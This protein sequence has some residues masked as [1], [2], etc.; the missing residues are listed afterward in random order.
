MQLTLKTLDV[1]VVGIQTANVLVRAYINATPIGTTTPWTNVV[2]N[3]TGVVN[4][5]L[6]QIADYGGG[7]VTVSGGEVT[8]GFWVSGTGSIDI[9]N[10]RDLGNCILG[11]GGANSNTQIYP[12]G[13]DVLTIVATNYTPG[14][15]VTL[16]GR[17]GWTEAQA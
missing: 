10:V 2:N 8:G 16:Q 11:G 12:D 13:P 7:S 6:A 17:I 1:S 14:T 9:S 5:S 15:S 3:V 4:S